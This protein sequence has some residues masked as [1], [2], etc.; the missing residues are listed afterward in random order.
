MQMQ[1]IPRILTTETALKLTGKS[2][3]Y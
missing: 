1:H 2:K 3:T